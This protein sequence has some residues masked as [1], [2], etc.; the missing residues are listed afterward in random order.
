MLEA[1]PAGGDDPELGRFAKL[2]RDYPSRGGK[3][4]RGRLVVLSAAAHGAPDLADALTVAAA[5]ELFQA[6]VLVHDDIEDGS[7]ER[8]GSPALHRLVGMPVAL[9]VGDAMHVH[10]W[11]LLHGLL[12]GP[13]TAETAQV[14]A[15]AA[16]A[17]RVLEEFGG[18]VTR[19]AEGQ[20]LDLAWVEDGRFDVGEAEYLTMVRL[21]TAWYTVASP[22]RLGAV[23]AGQEPSPALTSAAL[24]LGA[25]FQVRDDVLNLQTED[26]SPAYGKEALGDLYEGKRTLMLSHL[27]ASAHADVAEEVVSALSRPRA[28]R[29]EAQALQVL[30]HM[31]EHGSVAHAQRTADRLAA[32]GLSALEAALAGAPN[33]PVAAALL[34]ELADV[35]DRTS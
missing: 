4:L 30:A 26:G 33:R 13:P 14:A 5:L 31:R 27:L 8:R 21:K 6:W 12:A 18:M 29:T 11:R 22:L 35:A 9:N 23:L 7:E 24:D 16:L 17:T 3:T 2:Q 32:D 34:G 15:R 1:L 19:T 20:H 10:M 28:Q 25:A